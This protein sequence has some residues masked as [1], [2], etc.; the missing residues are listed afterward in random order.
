VVLTVICDP[1]HRLSGRVEYRK[2]YQEV[3]DHG[4]QSQRAMR[5][6]PM[7]THRGPDPSDGKQTQA[8]DQ[9]WPARRREEDQTCQRQRVDRYYVE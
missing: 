8:S 6:A 5:Q 2:E 9:H 1:V 7:R 3:L 4:I